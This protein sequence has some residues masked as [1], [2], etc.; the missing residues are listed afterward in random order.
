M[1]TEFQF[2]KMNIVLD[3]VRMVC[4]INVFNYTI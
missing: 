3:M 2:Y 4:N 1:F